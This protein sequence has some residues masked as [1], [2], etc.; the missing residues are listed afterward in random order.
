MDLP[1]NAWPW[2]N[3]YKFGDLTLLG[4]SLAGQGTSFLIP[5]LKIAFDV[6]FGLPYL[7]PARDY[8]V[9]HS[10]MDHAGGIPYLIS[11][12]SLMSQPPPRF[13]MPHEMK[14]PMT[15]VIEAWQQMEGYTYGYEFIGVEEGQW[16][17]LK[18]NWGVRP[19]KTKHRVPSL[20][21]TLFKTNKRLKPEYANFERQK[22]LDIKSQGH[23]LNENIEEPHISF[24]GDTQ[25][26]F[27]DG[28]EWVRRSKLLIMEAT[29]ADEQ[30]SITEAREWGHI[31]LHELFPRLKDLSCEKIL[32]IHLS[33]RH[34]SREL[35]DMLKLKL[36]QSW[37]DKVD[38]FPRDEFK[39]RPLDERTL[40]F[41]ERFRQV[42]GMKP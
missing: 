20:G 38:V 25:I 37:H 35:Q 11:Q 12:K 28:P 39:A 32:L 7:V 3:S 34:R 29:Y 41:F 5:E 22:L 18:G 2:P 24:T 30:K 26:E 23:E 40:S 8:F 33:A 31:H 27:L 14:E 9:S 21:Y 1:Q 13:F 19:F 15:R 17:Q 16:I 42:L 6:A 4:N 36:P 10:H